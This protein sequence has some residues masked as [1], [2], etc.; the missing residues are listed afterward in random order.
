M[1]LKLAAAVAMA[2]ADAAVLTIDAGASAS[3]LVVYD[4]TEPA[5]V[6]TAITDQVALVTF[7]LP[8]PAFGAS[9]D[10]AGGATATANAISSVTAAADGTASWFRIIDGNG[11]VKMQGSVTDT[12]GNGDLKVS[13]TSI[14]AGIEVSVISLTITMPKS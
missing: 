6:T 12:T 4:K 10:G 11:V 9:T 13:S 14:V 8:D 5:A 2:A 1:A 3:T 7:A